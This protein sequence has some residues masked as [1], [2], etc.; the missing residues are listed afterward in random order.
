VTQHPTGP[1]SSGSLIASATSTKLSGRWLVVVRAAWV[2]VALLALA[3][4][5]M[6]IPIRF[7]ALSSMCRSYPCGEVGLG[8]KDAVAL[9]Q[10]G[11]STVFYAAYNVAVE[12]VIAAV[13]WTVG[14]VIFWRNSQDKMAV[15]S[16]FIL[17]TY[18]M[19]VTTFPSG[20]K[21]KIP[22]PL[23]SC[24]P[25]VGAIPL[26]SPRGSHATCIGSSPYRL[27]RSGPL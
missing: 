1:R 4:L 2:A 9:R 19:Y 13:F 6:S 7:E 15:F 14:A 11:L 25:P 5:L 22:M 24:S 27:R 18:G 21:R 8:L 12:S 10:L 23:I 3:V 26:N 17:V 20:E 16:A